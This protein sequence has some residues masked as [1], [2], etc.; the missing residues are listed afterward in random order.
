MKPAGGQADALSRCG[1]WRTRNQRGANANAAGMRFM[2]TV[3][4]TPWTSTWSIPRGR[5]ADN[6]VIFGRCIRR[7]RSPS[8]ISFVRR[9][10]SKRR[11]SIVASWNAAGEGGHVCHHRPSRKNSRF[12]AKKIPLTSFRSSTRCPACSRSWIRIRRFELAGR[13]KILRWFTGRRATIYTTLYLHM[14]MHVCTYGT[15]RTRLDF[16]HPP[17]E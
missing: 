10:Y 15:M 3:A 12:P 7:F 16:L 8:R 14:Y 2:H 11:D 6:S 17:S 9:C 5:L 13:A 1:R 4:R